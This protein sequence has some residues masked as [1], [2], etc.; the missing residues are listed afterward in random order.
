MSIVKDGQ[1]CPSYIEL[2]TTADLQ[3]LS[4]GKSRRFIKSPM[5]LR[6]TIGKLFRIL[7]Q[8]NPEFIRCGG[9]VKNGD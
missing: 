3:T 2:L 6:E 4:E 1:E 8:L 5:V 7:S 9:T